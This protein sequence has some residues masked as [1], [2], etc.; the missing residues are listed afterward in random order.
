MADEKVMKDQVLLDTIEMI[1]YLL[2]PGHLATSDAMVVW[3]IRENLRVLV[4]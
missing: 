1:D 2:V 4:K 3:K